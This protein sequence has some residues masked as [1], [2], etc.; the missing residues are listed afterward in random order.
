MAEWPGD[1]QWYFAKIQSKNMDG[2]YDVAYEDGDVESHKPA[3]EMRVPTEKEQLQPRQLAHGKVFFSKKAKEWVAF[4][5]GRKRLPGSFASVDED[6][7]PARVLSVTVALS[8][9][10]VY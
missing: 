5:L 10:H 3:K 2:T 9:C 6:G 4:Y 1:G 7:C 8:R